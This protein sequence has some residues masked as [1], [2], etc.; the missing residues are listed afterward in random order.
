MGQTDS[1]QAAA[2]KIN[3]HDFALRVKEV[4][5]NDNIEEFKK[6]WQQ[7]PYIMK[8]EENYL[9]SIL[10][11]GV[12]DS[13]KAAFRSQK[14]EWRRTGIEVARMFFDVEKARKQLV[15]ADFIGSVLLI[16]LPEATINAE[17]AEKELTLAEHQKQQEEQEEL[18]LLAAETF[19]DMANYKEFLDPLCTTSVLNFLC[20]VLNQLPKAQ[21]IVTRTFVKLSQDKHNLIVL[22]EGAMGDILETFFKTVPFEKP[23]NAEDKRALEQWAVGT[24]ALSNTAQALGMLIK[25]HHPCQVDM[26]TIIKVFQY[27]LAMVV[28]EQNKGDIT[29]IEPKID[30]TSL[31]HIPDNIQLLAEL[32]RLF[33]WKCRST[34]NTTEL[35]KSSA[36]PAL[37]LDSEAGLDFVLRV[38]IAMW[39]RCIETQRMLTAVASGGKLDPEIQK[40]YDAFCVDDLQRRIPLDLSKEADQKAL[41][42]KKRYA[43]MRLCYLN[44][45]LW[46]LLPMKNLRW[47]LKDFGG[48][49]LEKKSKDSS[50]SI[51]KNRPSAENQ[52]LQMHLAFTLMDEEYLLVVLGT[53]R[54]LVDFPPAQESSEFIMFF[55]QQLL[56]LLELTSKG[57]ITSLK[58]ISVLLDAISILA[59]GRDM[60]EMLAKSAIHEQ[61]QRLPEA[62]EGLHDEGSADLDLERMK[63]DKVDLAILRCLAE[64]SIHP[65]HRLKW[66]DKEAQCDDKGVFK[67]YVDSE[68]KIHLQDKLQTAQENADNMKTL[69]SLLLT[70]LKEEKFRRPASEIEGMFR[71]VADWW[72]GNSTSQFD[73]HT[74][75]GVEGNQNVIKRPEINLQKLMSDAEWR[76]KQGLVVTVEE[77]QKIAAPHEC[78]I[79]L[80][81]FSRLALEPKFK[82]LFIEHNILDPLLGCICTG[83]WSEAREAAA[84]LANL[85]WLPDLKEEGLV[86]WLKFDGPR[87]I[88]VDASNVLMPVKTGT[89]KGVDIGK[90]MYKSS[91]GVEFVEGT[92]VTLHPKGLKTHQVPGMLTTAPPSHT[93]RSTSMKFYDWFDEQSLSGDNEKWFTITCWFYSDEKVVKGGHKRRVL[94]HSTPREED[95]DPGKPLVYMDITSGDGIK[96]PSARWMIQGKTGAGSTLE[97]KSPTKLTTPELKD[98]WHMLSVVSSTD[99]NKDNPFNG[100]KFYLDNW[101]DGGLL[102]KDT[103]LPNDFFMVGNSPNHKEPFGLITDFRIYSR[104]LKEKDLHTMVSARD[105]EHGPDQIARML[106]QKD[107]ASIL[108]LRLD[109]PDSAAECLRA[110]GSLATLS[111]QRAKIFSVC[112]RRVLQLIDSPMPMIQRQAARL[113][114]N[115]A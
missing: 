105:S 69:A 85:M 51:E 71:S 78:V 3:A 38:L 60:Q 106:A 29:K 104:V 98:G 9:A 32:S 90:G 113:I 15:R 59:M 75:V 58:A 110:L 54:Y 61:L 46:V 93:F 64:V 21:D 50:S 82:S 87:C 44:C 28:D 8:S 4:Y 73:T 84:T 103:W 35:M 45:T 99:S 97:W 115:I 70:I 33:Y 66:V 7:V 91:W 23:A 14:L 13:V 56:K 34:P 88:T 6:L 83:T 76:Q 42:E 95:N 62:L 107:A 100:T 17:D 25:Y 80:S 36:P 47:K 109:V 89:P 57:Q 22:M 92:C 63:K 20:I 111:S 24:K 72:M 19:C 5:K 102:L 12:M 77:T 26:P 112:G 55:G 18:Q 52:G 108:A 41:E 53:V 37:N 67:G 16:T 65:S 40:A 79:V 39:Q 30:V 96:A 43:E 1:T 68:F 49:L 48:K 2:E 74:M 86:C 27:S 10:A 94:L 101:P 114:N 31:D 11:D 81:L